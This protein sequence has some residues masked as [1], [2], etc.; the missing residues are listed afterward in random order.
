MSLAEAVIEG[1][2]RAMAKLIRAIDDRVDGYRDELRAVFPAAGRAKVVGVT[3]GPGVGKSTIV[4]ALIGVYRSR[5]ETVGVIA[6]D[7]SSPI[8]GGALLG[9]RARMRRHD[10]DEGVFIHSLAARG[11][12]GGL[13]IAAMG[14]RDVLDAGG[15]DRVIIETVG[16]GQQDVDVSALVHTTALVVQ[17]GTGD[18]L[19]LLKAGVIEVCDVAVVNKA[20]LPGAESVVRGISSVFAS[21]SAESD[22]WRRP[23]LSLV[24]TRAQGVDDLAITID[25]HLD[26]LDSSSAG[27]SRDVARWRTALLAIIVE[28]VGEFVLESFREEVDAS[29]ARLEARQSDPQTEALAILREAASRSFSANRNRTR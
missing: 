17:P 16:V 27:V 26:Y 19:Q 12:C 14:A 23:V 15:F 29:I 8:S 4:D 9:D 5:G 28:R 11:H 13:S 18:G 3:G 20:D 1:D 22:G 25:Q 7:P 24:A 10:G 2:R 6:I 21:R